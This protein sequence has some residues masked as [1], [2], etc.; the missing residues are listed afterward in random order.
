MFK[1]ELLDHTYG[2]ETEP[3]FFDTVA[4]ALDY[5]ELNFWDLAPHVTR[6]EQ[7]MTNKEYN[8]HL[9]DVAKSVEG[10]K[11][12]ENRRGESGS[13]RMKYPPQH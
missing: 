1:L 4:E 12:R 6:E 5:A 2:E 3:I 8:Q 9:K 13:S 10:G 11:G 7:A